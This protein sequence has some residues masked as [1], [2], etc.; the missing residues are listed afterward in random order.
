MPLNKPNTGYCS[1]VDRG[2]SACLAMQSLADPVSLCAIVDKCLLEPRV[3]Q[4][5]LCGDPALG[6]VYKDLLQQIQE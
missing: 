4:C 1:C 6:I 2:L 5:L 3:L